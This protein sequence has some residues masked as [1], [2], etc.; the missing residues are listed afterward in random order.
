MRVLTT[1]IVISVTSVICFAQKEYISS[2]RYIGR[3]NDTYF[4]FQFG[5]RRGIPR[6]HL[7]EYSLVDDLLVF[8]KAIPWQT[9]SKGVPQYISDTLEVFN[10]GNSTILISTSNKDSTFHV[11]GSIDFFNVEFLEETY[12][13]DSI[14]LSPHSETHIRLLNKR[15]FEFTPLPLI[16]SNLYVR[17]N[18]LFFEAPRYSDY[19]SSFPYDVYR[20]RLN[21]LKN[22]EKVLIQVNKWYPY[23]DQILFA[24]T[25]PF[26]R[27]NDRQTNGFYNLQNQT[28][29]ECSGIATQDII[30][31]SGKP[32]LLKIIEKDG[33]KVFKL[34]GIPNPPETFPYKTSENGNQQPLG[35]LFRWYN[36]PLKEKTF[37]SSF[38][39]HDLL[40]NAPESE[41]NNLSRKEL[42]I[43]RNAFYAFQGYKFSNPDLSEF[44]SQFD[45]YQK[46]SMGNK[47]NDD[48]VIWPDEKIRVELIKKIEDSK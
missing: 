29:A 1:L 23:T 41:L 26:L 45:W 10:L 28:I 18:Y 22:P 32:F 25:D 4:F 2:H 36:L 43:L 21:D 31:I 15:T 42:R 38:I 34:E 47:S 20:V 19:Y 30:E 3:K 7:V 12:S 11:A 16:G 48:I 24:S 8:S 44:F 13:T 33:E 6:P 5:S 39:T 37:G 46:M 40:F 9:A 14:F 35:E 27:L 17:D